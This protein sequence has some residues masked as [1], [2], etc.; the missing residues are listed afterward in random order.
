[1]F[2]SHNDE[3]R[4]HRTKS[5]YYHYSINNSI[6]EQHFNTYNLTIGIYKLKTIVVHTSDVK[7]ERAREQ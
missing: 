3:R 2:H 7:I 6:H 5:P 1:M 4:K